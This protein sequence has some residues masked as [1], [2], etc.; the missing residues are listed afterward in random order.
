MELFNKV[1]KTY[2]SK[3]FNGMTFQEDRTP[4]RQGPAYDRANKVLMAAMDFL[5]ALSHWSTRRIGGDTGGDTV[6]NCYRYDYSNDYSNDY[7]SG[8]AQRS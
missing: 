2:I 8:S 6:L 4:G 3:F 5:R 1:M 7:S